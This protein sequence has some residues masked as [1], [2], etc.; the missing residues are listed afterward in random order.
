MELPQES[1][2]GGEQDPP[3]EFRVPLV[4]S[5]G[6]VSSECGLQLAWIG[7]LCRGCCM[8]DDRRKVEAIPG[9]TSGLGRSGFGNGYCPRLPAMFPTVGAVETGAR[10][11]PSEP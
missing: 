7:E 11:I 2:S 10:G 4:L 9:R 6:D 8:L 1:S 3:L 5:N